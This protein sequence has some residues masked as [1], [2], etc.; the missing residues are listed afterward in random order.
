MRADGRMPDELRPVTMEKGV[1][2][3][4]D[5]SVCIRW[6]NTHVLC[7][8]MLED[9]AVPFKVGTGTGWLTAEYAMLPGST[10]SRKKRDGLKTDGRSVEIRRL[11]G[12]ALRS[13]VDF[14]ALGE[15]TVWIDCDVISADGGTRTASITGAYVALALAVKKWLAEGILE[16]DPLMDSVAA[17]SCGIIDGEPRLDLAYVEDSRAEVDCNFVMTGKGRLVE[18]QGTGEHDTFS[19]EELL[20]MLDLAEKGIME[21][22][23]LQQ[24]VIGEE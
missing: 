21:L 13:V 19:R 6:G 8:A 16:K 17:V 9:K 23:A 3:N 10:P 15:R 24:A 2:L 12:R 22:K 1:M 7:T 5:G 4:A 20:A 14:E 11:I 18:V